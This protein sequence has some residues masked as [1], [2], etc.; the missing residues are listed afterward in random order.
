MK[1]LRERLT[2]ANVMSTIAVFLFLG[3]ATALA[4]QHLA[5]HSVGSKQLKANAVTTAKIKKEAVS[6][7]KIKK[8]AIDGSRIAEG[9]VT[10]DDIE[11]AST[12]FG[13]V[14]TRLRSTGTIAVPNG[15]VVQ[16][17]LGASTYTQA[18]DEVDMLAGAFDITFQAGCEAPRTVV[19]YIQ[20]DPKDPTK[21]T[22]ELEIASVGEIEDKT[23]GAVNMRLEA[24]PYLFLGTK[25]EPGVAKTRTANVL[26]EG[27]CKSGGGITAT[28]GAIDVLGTR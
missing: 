22:S 7:K 24:G 3:G 11:P 23:G 2:Y 8:N 25:F 16:Y 26:L 4:A 20:V 10:G 27:K 21:L 17:P 28:S 6:R 13:R 1:S 18:A 5:R 15:S 14:T 19:A 9:S 12:P